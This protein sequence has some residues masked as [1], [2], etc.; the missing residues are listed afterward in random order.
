MR[1]EGLSCDRNYERGL[2]KCSRS[3]VS[4]SI[5]SPFGLQLSELKQGLD[6]SSLAAELTALGI[7]AV[8]VFVA[9]PP[10]G[11]FQSLLS[12]N[13]TIAPFKDAAK[14][15]QASTANSPSEGSVLGERRRVRPWRRSGDEVNPC[16]AAAN[17]A[18]FS[19]S[20]SLAIAAR[21]G[22]D[23]IIFRSTRRTPLRRNSLILAIASPRTKLPNSGRKRPS[24]RTSRVQ[25]RFLTAIF[26]HRSRR[27]AFER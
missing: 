6:D 22:S 20:T 4:L 19:A 23:A 26:F 1:E 5:S 3:N 15:I 2:L 18:S 9:N 8:G 27:A 13:A 16:Q 14:C 11:H 25:K 10:I 7:T 21:S 12:G 17:Y 24:R